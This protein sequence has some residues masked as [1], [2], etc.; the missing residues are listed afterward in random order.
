MGEVAECACCIHIG[1]RESFGDKGAQSVLRPICHVPKRVLADEGTQKNE[2]HPAGVDPPGGVGGVIGTRIVEA[3][4]G[5][6]KVLAVAL[7][8]KTAVGEQHLQIYRVHDETA[9]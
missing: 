6:P 4:G 7:G 8:P 3:A 1:H 2:L 9:G 5:E